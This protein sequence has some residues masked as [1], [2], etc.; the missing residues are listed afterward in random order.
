MINIAIYKYDPTTYV[1]AKAYLLLH[2]TE[3]YGV[4]R[5]RVKPYLPSFF[6]E[7]LDA[8]KLDFNEFKIIN[9]E[10]FDWKDFFFILDRYYNKHFLLHKNHDKYATMERIYSEL[11]VKGPHL[12]KKSHSRL[13]IL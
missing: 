2:H 1:L 12:K 9:F 10:T 4:P 11:G 13:K 6:L 3:W 8:G 5:H 7:D